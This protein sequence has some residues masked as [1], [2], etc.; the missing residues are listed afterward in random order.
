[1]TKEFND[2]LKKQPD[3]KVKF[4]MTASGNTT[5]AMMPQVQRMQEDTP[6]HIE[7]WGSRTLRELAV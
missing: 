3:L 2:A 4:L 7:R 6:N 5:V 1:M